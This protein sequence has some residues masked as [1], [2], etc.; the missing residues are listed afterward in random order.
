MIGQFESA[1]KLLL[2]HYYDPRYA[3]AMSQ[4]E[5]ECFVIEVQTIEEAM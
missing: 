3:H 5:R 4:Y 2:E 1:V